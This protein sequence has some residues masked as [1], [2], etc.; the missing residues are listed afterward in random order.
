MRWAIARSLNGQEHDDAAVP[1]PPEGV[2]HQPMG[3]FVTLHK[4]GSLRGCIGA[5]I[6]EKPLY[7]TVARMARAAAFEDHRFSPVRVEELGEITFDISVLSPLT[8]CPG[9]QAIIPGK[10]GVLLQARGRSA[11]FL[12]QVATE[13]GWSVA[14]MLQNLC[15]KAGLPLD[16]WQDPDARLWWYEALCIQP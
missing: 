16:A 14:D 4:N 7:L 9:P 6:G 1:V 11:V 13:Q 5:M 15:R 2:L 10:H 3:A 8:P 12:P